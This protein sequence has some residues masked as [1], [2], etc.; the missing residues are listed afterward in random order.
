MVSGIREKTVTGL[1]ED[2]CHRASGE[3]LLWWDKGD[4]DF[5]GNAVMVKEMD[6]MGRGKAVRDVR[7]VEGFLGCRGQEKNEIL[8]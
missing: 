4:P 5:T 2:I 8:V 7:K 1:C 3:V 6:N